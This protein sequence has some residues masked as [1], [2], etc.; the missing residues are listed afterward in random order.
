MLIVPWKDA[1]F[2]VMVNGTLTILPLRAYPAGTICQNGL[3]PLYRLHL[4]FFHF[5][6]K[7]ADGLF[8]FLNGKFFLIKIQFYLA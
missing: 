8:N 3:L 2:L 1:V 5:I 7:R 6:P 4:G